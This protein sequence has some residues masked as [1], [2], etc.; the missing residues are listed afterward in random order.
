M[1]WLRSDADLLIMALALGVVSLA[2]ASGSFVLALVGQH[3]SSAA[4]IV[5]VGA[6][7]LAWV[8]TA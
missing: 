1:A 3:G 2:Y 4:E 5:T 7:L 8:L 6:Y